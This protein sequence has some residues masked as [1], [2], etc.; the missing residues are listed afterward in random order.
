MKVEFSDKYLVGDIGKPSGW[1]DFDFWNTLTLEYRIC[2]DGTVEIYMPSVSNYEITGY[3]LAGTYQLTENE[4]DYLKEVINQKKLYRLDPKEDR[5]VC[6]GEE[7]ILCLYDKDGQ[8]LKE[9]GGYMPQ[10]K[11]FVTMYTA[12]MSTLHLDEHYRIRHE[13]INGLK[14]ELFDSFLNNQIEAY[15]ES[16]ESFLYRDISELDEDEY[17]CE[18]RYNEDDAYADIDNDG[19]LELT[20]WGAY[21]GFFIDDSDEKLVVMAAGEGSAAVLNYVYHDGEIWLV[22]SDTSHAGRAMRHFIKYEGHGNIA[23]EFDLDAEYWESEVDHY[24]ET[25]IF[26][27]RGEEISMDEY[28][29]IL[30]E[31]DENH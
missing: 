17:W 20:L 28:E 3:E 30:A 26:T 12:I 16:G 11:D 21:G 6:D 10:N 7:R 9:C 8:V 14:K 2:Y 1:G 13:W 25:S 15:Y 4:I 5:D 29:K 24:D 22:Y 31:Y 19:D 23:D 27:Y 18:I